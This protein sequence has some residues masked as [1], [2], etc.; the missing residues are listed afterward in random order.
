VTQ[1][2]AE[3]IIIA[4]NPDLKLQEGDIQKKFAFKTK[5]KTRNLVI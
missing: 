4:Q 3:D 1:E 5:K 2:N